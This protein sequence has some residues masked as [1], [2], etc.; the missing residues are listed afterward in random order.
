MDW[1]GECEVE[2]PDQRQ[3]QCNALWYLSKKELPEEKEI[4]KSVSVACREGRKR[5]L[6]LEAMEKNKQTGKPI[7]G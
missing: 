6:N 3:L 4:L 1:K 5:A 2:R 7:E